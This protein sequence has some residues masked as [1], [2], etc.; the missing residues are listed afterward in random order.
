MPVQVRI[1]TPLRR[2]TGDKALVE[3]PAGTVAAALEALFALFPGL[4]PN[5]VDDDGRVRGFVNVYVGG[6]DIRFLDGLETPVADG[7]QIALVPA[8]AG[9]SGVLSREEVSRYSRYLLL[10]EFGIAG[11]ERL[12]KGSV[13]LVGT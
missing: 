12:K 10:P 9:G 7:E 5:V 13:L 2:H 3:V 1:P 8:I 4:K 6:D 11:Q